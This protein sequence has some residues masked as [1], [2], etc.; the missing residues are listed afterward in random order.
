MKKDLKYFKS[1]KY[2]M[3]VEYL[4]DESIYLISFPDLPGCLMHGDDLN[5]AINKALVVKDEWVE[6]AFEKGW[7]IP[8][9]SIP[10]ETSGRLTLR[11]PKSMQKKVIDRAEEEGVSQNQLIVTFIAEG[12]ERFSIKESINEIIDTQNK[13]FER[14]SVQSTQAITSNPYSQL[15]ICAAETFVSA[16]SENTASLLAYPQVL[17]RPKQ[18]K[19]LAGSLRGL[20]YITNRPDYAVSRTGSANGES[21]LSIDDKEELRL[22]A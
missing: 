19:V 12:L 7:A 14:I 8:E 4:T 1:L 6:T 18:E 10:L 3:V 9:P 20:G 15:I 22:E 11:I 17:Q 5:E 13:I 2:K 16:A 21:N